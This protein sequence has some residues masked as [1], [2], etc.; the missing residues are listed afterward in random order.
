MRTHANTL[1]AIG[2]VLASCSSETVARP[3]P[4]PVNWQSLEAHP[5]KDAGPD[6]VTEKERALAGAYTSALVLPGFASLGPLLD[7]EAHF[8]SP[9]MDDA[10]GPGP[11]V[12]AHDVLFG[13][14]DERKVATSRVW[15]TPS[16]QTLEWTMTGMQARDW[17]GVASTHKPVTFK[18]LTLLWTKDD[19]SVTD[20]H[21]YIDVALVKA[22]LGVGPKELLGVPAPSMP[23]GST[24]VFEQTAGS[25]DEQSHVAVMQSWL[26]ALENNNESG[27]V[28]AVTEDIEVYTLEHPQPARGKEAARSYYKAMHKAIGELDTT[29]DN[30]WGVGQFSVVEYSIAGEQLAPM[31][32]VPAQRD[33]VIR[34]QLVDICETV[35]G[36]VARV[37]RY[38]NPAQILSSSVR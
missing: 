33:K 17:M 37:W 23:T 25:A 38:D 32:W 24:Q 16:E 12:H 18:G 2:L 28:G 21:V 4:P 8:S 6:L 7:D 31:A 10:H 30:A 22:Q 13:A 1:S 11:V 20:I 34:L 19:G 3:P 27:Y 29:V 36:K 5:V 26:D 35:G 9:G 15:R 14:F